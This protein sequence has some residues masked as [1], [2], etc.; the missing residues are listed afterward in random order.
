MQQCWNL[1]PPGKGHA[2]TSTIYEHIFFLEIME[3]RLKESVY[4]WYVGNLYCRL[5]CNGLNPLKSLLSLRDVL[6]S[7]KKYP[8]AILHSAYTA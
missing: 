2:N 7:T 6:N 4:V 1:K 5:Q 8:K 3:K